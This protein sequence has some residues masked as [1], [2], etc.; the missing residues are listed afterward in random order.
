MILQQSNSVILSSYHKTCLAKGSKSDGEVTPERY[1]LE[2][3]DWDYTA[4]LDLLHWFSGNLGLY[5]K[6]YDQQDGWNLTKGKFESQDI[7]FSWNIKP[8]SGNL[9]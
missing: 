9:S 8:K 5:T 7:E 2:F 6:Y 1:A 4:S 3:Q